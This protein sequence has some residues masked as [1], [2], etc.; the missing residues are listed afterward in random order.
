MQTA[1]QLRSALSERVLVADGA[2][3]TMLQ[4]A[5][6][7][8][9]DFQGH[10][11][12]NEV[13]NATRPDVVA[14][15][16]D[17]YF[18]VGVD[19][20]ETNT[21]GANLANLAE[22]GIS[23]RIEELAGR[24]SPDR[25]RGRRRL[26]HR[27][28]SALGDRIGR[29][30][31]QAADAG[32]RALRRAAGRLPGAGRRP[33]GRRGRRRARRDR[34]GPPAGQVGGRGGPSRGRRVRPRRPRLGAG[35]R[36]DDRDDAAGQRDRRRAR[37]AR[38]ARRRDDRAELRHRPGGD[39]R[40]PP[41]PRT[42][43][44]DLPVLHAQRGPAG[45]DLRRRPLPADAGGARRRAR[46][47]HPR[48]RPLAR[49]RLLR[50]HP[51]AP[52]PGGRARRRSRR[53]VPPAASRTRRGEPLPG[54]PVPAGHRV[55]LDRRA[56]ERQR[57]QGLPRGD[58]RGA[59]GGVRAR[60]RGPRSATARTCSTCASTTSAATA[61]PTWRRWPRAWPPPRPCRSSSTRPSPRCWRRAWRC[62]AADLS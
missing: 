21:F 52:A 23:D 48:L 43:R 10:E 41:P 44:A 25:P 4:A 28:P 57:L 39:E 49:R 3:G 55:P 1:A 36:R 40:A 8:L 6:L 20:V 60:S 5:D 14:A 58:G 45:A 62:S 24:G 32:P 61:S 33:G 13:L 19:A 18:A 30:G 31:H 12:C 47:V 50:D 53:T 11:G 54:G 17:A 9:D 59:V 27:G 15:V 38:A 46:R 26:V 22:Y 56:D 42:A 37:R 51:G 34:A 2:M 29:A 16:H 7:T 35:D